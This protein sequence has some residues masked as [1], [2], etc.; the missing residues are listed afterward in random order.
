MGDCLTFQHIF[1]SGRD[2]LPA[3][4]MFVLILTCFSQ[5]NMSGG[6]VSRALN[7]PDCF[8]LFFCDSDFFCEKSLVWSLPVTERRDT[9]T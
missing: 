2:T 1:T 8:C 4:I 5:W 3:P 7:V 9:R 6:E